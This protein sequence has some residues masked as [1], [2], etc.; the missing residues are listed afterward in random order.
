MRGEGLGLVLLPVVALALVQARARRAL[1]R[2]V[3]CMRVMGR[4]RVRRD[5][6]T[7]GV[8]AGRGRSCDLGVRRGLRRGDP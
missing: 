1:G 5:G 6:R 2:A 7:V 8:R 4:L 3:A